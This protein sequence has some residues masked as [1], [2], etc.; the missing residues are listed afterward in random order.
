MWFLP[1]LFTI[2][3][4]I[5]PLLRALKINSLHFRGGYL[6]IIIATIVLLIALDLLL[7]RISFMQ[8]SSAIHY[9][10]FFLLG[11]LYC[12][13]KSTIDRFL[14]KYWI[15]I[16]FSFLI[17]SV[18]M[19]LPK[20]MSSL[21]GIIFSITFA[22][23]LENKCPDKYV[24]L[25]GLCYIVFLLSYFPQMFIRG[26]IAHRFPEVN[27]YIFSVISFLT[28]LLLPIC[29]GLIFL[30]YKHKYKSLDKLGLLIG[31]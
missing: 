6:A 15:I 28:G 11:I 1:A 8:L 18:S 22:L 24:K 21:C 27:Q 12:D 14:K 9:S 5:Y 7:P 29:F 16:G 31:L 13:Y 30:K 10:T 4:L 26:P 2:F 3:L 25:S 17:L 20:Y 23:I 19:V